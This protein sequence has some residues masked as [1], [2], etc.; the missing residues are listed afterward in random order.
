MAGQ[1]ERGDGIGRTW[2]V[3][4]LRAA[5][6]RAAAGGA[7]DAAVGDL[8][9]APRS[10]L[11]PVRA[12]VCRAGNRRAPQRR[13]GCVERLREALA[14]ASDASLRARAGVALARALVLADRVS[15][16][17]DTSVAQR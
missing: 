1:L 3:E 4:T 13:P 6:R 9:R 17:S 10:R 7:D 14:A 15:D 5:A 2:A 12:E 11:P 16:A 8:R